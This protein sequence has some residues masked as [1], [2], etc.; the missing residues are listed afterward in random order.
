MMFTSRLSTSLEGPKPSDLIIS[1]NSMKIKKSSTQQKSSN[2]PVIIHE[3]SPKVI[4]VQPQEFMQLVQRLTGNT[5][6]SS[7]SNYCSNSYVA[8]HVVDNS[9]KE[10]MRNEESQKK[11]GNT[12]AVDEHKQQA[13]NFEIFSPMRSSKFLS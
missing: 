9:H 7:N 1:R 4:H 2:G 6:S 13:A 3:R 10:E 11:F 12:D 5:S 8:M